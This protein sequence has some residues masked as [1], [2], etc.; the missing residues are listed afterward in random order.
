[1]AINRRRSDR[2]ML[3][4]PLRIVG[5]DAQGAEFK[6]DARTVTINRHGARIRVSRPLSA[7]GTI[8]LANT[9]S[10]RESDFR[11][12]G[13]V[14]PLSEAGGDWGVECLDPKE[15]IWGIQFPPLEEGQAA[16]SKALVECR[17]CHTVALMPL[18]LVE[19]EVLDTS[20][21]VQKHCQ[22]CDATSP[23]GYA[24]SQI[25]LTAPMDSTM[26]FSDSQAETSTPI[27]R[28][29]LRRH[30]RVALQLT[31]RVRDYYGGEEITKSEN[32]SKGGFCFASEKNYMIGQGLMV[33][34]P[35]NPTAQNI[36]VGARIVRKHDV[37]EVSRKVYGVRYD[38]HRR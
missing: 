2:I 24:E 10:R 34:C 28:S 13:P 21:I 8:R 11:L 23:W 32:V 7:S 22:S 3:A 31:V 25:A 33:V 4:I 12:V 29:D 17:R 5:T 14:T 16:E 18:S 30:R 35:Y 38:V 9:L 26:P 1:M 27:T 37:S 15:N 19:V 6:E 20:G 36:E